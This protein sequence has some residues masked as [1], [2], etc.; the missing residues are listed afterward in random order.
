MK[1]AISLSILL[2]FSGAVTAQTVTYSEHI[3]PI[4]YNHCTSC[5]RPGEIAPF[6]LTSYSEVLSWGGMIKYVTDIKFMPP[7]KA[8][9]TY[10]RYQK[11]NFLSDNQIQLIKDWVDS[12]M[13]QG[14]PNLEPPL[15]QFPTGSQI[16]VP[17]LVLSFAQSHTIQDNNQDE[18]RYFILPTGLTVDKDLIALEVR[19]GNMSKVHHALCWAD[20]TGQ[21]AAA[22]AATPEYGYENVSGSVG[23]NGLNSQ[24][25]GYVPGQKPTLLTNGIAQRLPA[26]SDLKIQ[27]HYAPSTVIETDSTT[28]NLFFA[29]QPAMRYL[30][31]KVMVPFLGTLTNGPFVIQ[32]NTVKRF[33]GTWTVPEKVSLM[34]INP[35]MHMLGKDWEVFAVT[36]VNDT[37]PLI[38]INEWDFNWQGTF[39]F[40]QLIVLPINSVIHAYASYDNTTNN[41]NNPNNPPQQVGWGEN[42][43]DEMYYLPI[44]YLSYQQGDENVTFEEVTGIGNSPYYIANSKLYPIA[45]N[46]TSSTVKIGYT[47]ADRCS[48]SL[49]VYD[50][51]GR[52]MTTLLNNQCHMP[53]MHTIEV[54]VSSFPSGVY[55]V[56][57]VNA[58]NRQTQ[59]LVVAN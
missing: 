49:C 1:N 48:V 20:T 7:W 21:G 22:D 44:L 37:I 58:G 15:P 52:K 27:I 40:K 54:D 9:P 33:H 24:L 32:P 23:L 42:T 17:D 34:A 47:L 38:K 55:F 4:I 50:M 51:N 16:G 35:H 3:A 28:V 36:P 11:E 56:V 46:P 19:P 8:D 2:A 10:Q 43:S 53:G 39:Y 5:H 25:P 6:S 31:S 14:D 13:P 12:G 59:K 45:P 57:M 30:K 41:I 26:G 18:Y 29:Q